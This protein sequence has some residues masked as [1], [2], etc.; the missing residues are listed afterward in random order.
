VNSKGTALGPIQSFL[1]TTEIPLPVSLVAYEAQLIAGNH[2]KLT[3]RTAQE[4][5]SNHFVI[6]KSTDGI[7]FVPIGRV[8]SKGNSSTLTD[9]TFTDIAFTM[10]SA[11]YRLKQVD[12]D[13][14]STES[15]TRKVNQ[16]S[17]Q[18]KASLYPNPVTNNFFTVETGASIILPVAYKIVTVTG[19]QVQEGLLKKP[20]EQ[21]N[22][23]AISQGHYILEL[24]DGSIIRF[25][26]D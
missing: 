21:V 4:S 6:E 15:G 14:R 23:S 2:V 10:A 20:N 22:I 17:S 7:R 18:N 8:E 9:Y 3:W 1:T 25:R 16:N 11:F 19:Q 24:S 13:G 5:N 12:K 26:K